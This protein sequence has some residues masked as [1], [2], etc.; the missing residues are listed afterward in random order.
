V[1]APLS[2][3]SPSFQERFPSD[4]DEERDSVPGV[5]PTYYL[6]RRIARFCSPPEAGR[7]ITGVARCGSEYTAP[8]SRHRAVGNHI[9]LP[10]LRGPRRCDSEGAARLKNLGYALGRPA[11][12]RRERPGDSCEILRFAQNHSWQL[13]LAPWRMK[14]AVPVNASSRGNGTGIQHQIHVQVHAIGGSS[15]LH[16][17]CY[18]CARSFLL[19]VYPVCTSQAPLP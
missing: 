1:P 14:M 8:L 17:M 4:C 3:L 12:G 10:L 2:A 16:H 11:I 9:R 7:G 15:R 6:R 13:R 5:S 18:P 19:P